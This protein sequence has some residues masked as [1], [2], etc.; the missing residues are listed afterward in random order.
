MDSSKDAK[1]AGKRIKE[2]REKKKLTQA[3][4]AKKAGMNIN[5]FAVIERGEVVTTWPKLQKISDA[6]GVDISEISSK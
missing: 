2:I 5:Y 1:Q 4:V 3:E 6:L